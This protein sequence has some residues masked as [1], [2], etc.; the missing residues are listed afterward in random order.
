MQ[1]HPLPAWHFEDEQWTD[2]SD[3]WLD[4]SVRIVGADR[5]AEPDACMHEASMLLLRI[6]PAC[7]L[8]A[9]GGT[10]AASVLFSLLR[11]FGSDEPSVPVILKAIRR[12]VAVLRSS[13]RREAISLPQRTPIEVDGPGV[14]LKVY[15]TGNDLVLPHHYLG[16]RDD[17]MQFYYPESQYRDVTT[18]EVRERARDAAGATA[19]SGQMR[20]ISTHPETLAAL[21]R[22][23]P[24]PLAFAGPSINLIRLDRSPGGG[25]ESTRFGINFTSDGCWVTSL[26]CKRSDF[27]E[28]LRMY[29]ACF[30]SAVSAVAPVGPIA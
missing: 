19:Y 2:V 9:L 15:H 30:R 29:P 8:D 10:R 4:A 3:R 12:P 24:I 6:F 17:P 28:F 11:Q 26:W 23:T 22:G 5:L 18:V 13:G 7:D 1:K 21:M 25:L 14:R 27:G 16:L 20:S